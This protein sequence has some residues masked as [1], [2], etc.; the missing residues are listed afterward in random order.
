V[1]GRIATVPLVRAQ[2]L[3]TEAAQV[4]GCED[5]VVV[6]D[7]EGLGAN[8]FNDKPSLDRTIERFARNHTST[9]AIAVVTRPIRVNGRFGLAATT[10]GCKKSTLSA[11]ILAA[12]A[13]TRR[14]VKYFV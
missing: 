9:T 1:T 2:K 8:L 10:T 12:R 3:E 5:A 11:A 6:I 4:S 14:Q 13:Q 7:A